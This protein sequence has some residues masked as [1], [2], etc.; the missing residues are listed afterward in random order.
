M[1]TPAAITL[2]TAT[3]VVVALGLTLFLGLISPKRFAQL[4]GGAACGLTLVCTG[5]W[6]ADGGGH[7]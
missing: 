3:L 1:P 6:L 7:G 5:V 2:G 4:L